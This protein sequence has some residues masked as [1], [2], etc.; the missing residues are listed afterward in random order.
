MVKITITVDKEHLE[1]LIYPALTTQEKWCEAVDVVEAAIAEA[2]AK[3]HCFKCKEEPVIDELVFCDSCA[4]WFCYEHIHSGEDC[5][6][7]DECLYR[8]EKGAANEKE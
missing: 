4:R 7:C 6:L 3:S 5:D 1:A 8:L 2:E